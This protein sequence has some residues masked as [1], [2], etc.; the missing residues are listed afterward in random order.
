MIMFWMFLSVV[1]AFG[2]VRLLEFGWMNRP[3]VS[4]R[5]WPKARAMRFMWAG[6]GLV[7][8]LGQIPLGILA[9]FAGLPVCLAHLRLVDRNSM[10][11]IGVMDV[12]NDIYRVGRAAIR[13][14]FNRTRIRPN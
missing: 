14:L 5:Q 2:F 11:E 1:C 6:I 3:P 7:I 9:S 10:T 13:R 12:A 8:V 4:V